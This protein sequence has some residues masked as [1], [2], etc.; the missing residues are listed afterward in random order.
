MPEPQLAMT[1]GLRKKPFT[2]TCQEPHRQSPCHTSAVPP[3]RQ[4]PKNSGGPNSNDG[5]T[6][7]AALP[8]MEGRCSPTK[9]TPAALLSEAIRCIITPEGQFV[10]LFLTNSQHRIGRLPF[11]ALRPKPS[12]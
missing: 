7:Q 3:S 11:V 1:N 9:V 2:Q 4:W 12:L 10:P 6:G 5:A 8:M